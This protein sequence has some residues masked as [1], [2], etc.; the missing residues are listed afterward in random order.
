MSNETEKTYTTKDVT[1][2]PII[3]KDFGSRAQVDLVDMQSYVK[4][5]YDWIMVYQDHLT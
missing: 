4:E 2:K 3:S 5:K 1:V